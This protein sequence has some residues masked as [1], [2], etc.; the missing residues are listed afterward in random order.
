MFLTKNVSSKLISV[1]G[2]VSDSTFFEK[3]GYVIGELSI[4]L[5]KSAMIERDYLYGKL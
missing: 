3:V 4:Y 2:R 1:N 5:T